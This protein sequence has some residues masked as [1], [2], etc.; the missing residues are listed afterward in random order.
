MNHLLP[1]RIE[2][3]GDLD[4]DEKG[5]FQVNPKA[6]IGGGLWRLPVK[7]L[8]PARNELGGCFDPDAKD[9]FAVNVRALPIWYN[10]GMTDR[11]K[12][13]A[14]TIRL[15]AADWEA[16]ARIKELYGCP[17]DNAAV[18]LALR[19]TARQSCETL[20]HPPARPNTPL[21]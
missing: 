15:D 9:V 3:G 10:C 13:A 7:P 12:T 2:L 6:L 1:T 17:S 18:K 4:S 21:Q 16:L 8:L 19:M 14:K 5:V 20:S 11:H